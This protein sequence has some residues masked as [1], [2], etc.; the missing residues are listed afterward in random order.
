MKKI[1]ALF[2]IVLLVSCSRSDQ[3]VIQGVSDVPTRVIAFAPSIVETLYAMSL[4]DRIV[5]VSDYSNY[6]PEAEKH[7]VMGHTN[8]PDFER[9]L[10][11]RPDLILGVGAAEGLLKVSKKLGVRATSF[12]SET[13][14]HIIDIPKR[15]GSMLGVPEKGDQL[16]SQ[17]SDE[18]DRVRLRI[19]EPEKRPSVLIVIGKSER[20]VFTT[21][22]GTFLTELVALAGGDSVTA[23]SP[24]RWFS[25]DW[26]QVLAKKPEV[27]LVL[28]GFDHI[29]LP[30][31]EQILDRWNR[32]KSLP[33]VQNKRV[34]LV[35]GSHVV[36]SGPR[37]TQ[38][39]RDFA[40]LLHPELSSE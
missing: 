14:A 13:L 40:A 25:L 33:A 17:I 23:Q 4:E 1:F 9:M 12:P 29:A 32:Y 34:Y 39:A 38:T 7:T 28:M 6:P 16:A 27:V 30:E 19:G 36:K 37:V 35:I 2:F 11:A 20:E 10:Q 5:G 3:P 21:G 8:N 22:K 24:V 15:L 18:L 26:E 31:Q